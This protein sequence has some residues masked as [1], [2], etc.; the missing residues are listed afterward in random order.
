MKFFETMQLLKNLIGKSIFSCNEFT[1]FALCQNYFPIDF[2]F[3]FFFLTLYVH[4][5]CIEQSKGH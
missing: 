2:F 4:S 5:F 1:E 3:F